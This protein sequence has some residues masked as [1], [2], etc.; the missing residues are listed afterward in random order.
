MKNIKQPIIPV[1]R[2][3]DIAKTTEFYVDWLGFAID[4][5]HRFGDNFPVYMQ[6]SLNGVLLHLSEHHGDCSPGAKILIQ[7]DD[8]DAFHRQIAQKDYRYF[9]P[10]IQT[11][12]WHTRDMSLTDPFGNRLVFTQTVQPSS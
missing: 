8:I 2:I 5:Q 7:I 9:K 12:D 11:T 6:V 1:L 4:W 3:F 10:S